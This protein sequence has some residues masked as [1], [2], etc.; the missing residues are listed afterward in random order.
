MKIQ[1]KSWA[2]WIWSILAL[3]GFQVTMQAADLALSDVTNCASGAQSS[4][5][6][7]GGIGLSML[8]IAIAVSALL[9]GWRLRKGG[10]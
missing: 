8:T 2:V 7:M 4:F 9:F 3:L 10:K 5:N 1:I 6:L